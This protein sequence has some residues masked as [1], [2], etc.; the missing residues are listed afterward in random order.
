MKM[1]RNSLA[2]KIRVEPDWNRK[3]EMALDCS[4]N[5]IFFK[6]LKTE[7][8]IF[9]LIGLMKTL[10]KRIQ[11]THTP[12]VEDY[13]KHTDRHLAALALY[14]VAAYSDGDH[15]FFLRLGAAIQHDRNP[16]SHKEYALALLFC[17]VNGCGTEGKPCDFKNLS[18][19]L[20]KYNASITREKCKKLNIVLV[21]RRGRPRKNNSRV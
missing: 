19:F 10:A 3:I 20:R 12:P 16:G 2:H 1:K 7:Q 14:F 13:N 11:L 6:K 17:Q 5:P 8:D 4:R 21:S 18:E 15:K 9:W